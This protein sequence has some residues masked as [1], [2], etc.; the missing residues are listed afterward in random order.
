MEQSIQPDALWKA[1]ILG[2]NPSGSAIAKY[3]EMPELKREAALRQIFDHAKKLVGTL[4]AEE[5]KAQGD[6]RTGKN[7]ILT[8]IEAVPD[9]AN[10]PSLRAS[11]TQRLNELETESKKL[12]NDEISLSCSSAVER[13]R[14]PGRAELL[15]ALVVGG[16]VLSKAIT[17][18]K[19]MPLPGRTLVLT[20]ALK[21]I[22]ERADAS[23]K[24]LSA[25]QQLCDRPDFG[26]EKR[27]VVSA[28]EAIPSLAKGPENHSAANNYLEQV[29]KLSQ[30]LTD[31]ELA[32][33]CVA[34]EQKLQQN[35]FEQLRGPSLAILMIIPTDPKK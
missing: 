35:F 29:T 14:V 23:I 2:G 31:L 5:G 24:Y 11:A 32:G 26:R 15:A 25:N 28:L 22:L 18:L 30:R 19:A 34:A 6:F 33:K 1:L 3:S 20:E 16:D 7:N 9:L 4:L 21:M 12:T 17:E 13:L 27:I 8:V 10:T